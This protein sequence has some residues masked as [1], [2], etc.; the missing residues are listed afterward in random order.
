[1]KLRQQ[2]RH[3]AAAYLALLLQTGLLLERAFLPGDLLAFG[4][5]EQLSQNSCICTSF[6]QQRFLEHHGSVYVRLLHVHVESVNSKG[7][8][9]A[10]AVMQHNRCISCVCV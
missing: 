4:V 6:L 2:P 10:A 3:A 5:A 9:S 8:M 7:E 1:M